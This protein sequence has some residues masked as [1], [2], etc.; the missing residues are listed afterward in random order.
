MMGLTSLLML[1]GI[2]GLLIWGIKGMQQ[3]TVKNKRVTKMLLLGYGILL[4]ASIFVFEALPV[5]K[6]EPDFNASSDDQLDKEMNRLDEA[7]FDGRTDDIDSSLIL[8]EWKW[9]YNGKELFLQDQDW[10]DGTVVVERKADNDGIIEGTYYASS[11]IGGV[12]LTDEY[13]SR[14]VELED[15]TLHLKGKWEE[16]KLKFAVFEKEFVITQFTGERKG[17]HDFGGFRE[18]SYLYLKVPKDLKLTPQNEDLY[19]HYVGEDD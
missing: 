14:Q 12:D 16:K 5:N 8:N 6:K 13:R 17:A 19:I 7:I 10:F 15:D 3:N 11:V 1:I 9:R 4:A 2:A 18:I